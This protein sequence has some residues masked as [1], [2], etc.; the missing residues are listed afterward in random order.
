MHDLNMLLVIA[1]CVCSFLLGR[2]YRDFRDAIAAAHED[3]EDS[4]IYKEEETHHGK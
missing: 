3:E 2:I 4:D 1:A